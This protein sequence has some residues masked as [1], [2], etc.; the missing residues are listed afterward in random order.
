MITLRDSMVLAV[1]KLRTRKVRTII[2]ILLASMLFGLLITASM[3]TTGVFDS[4]D[5][6]RKDGL[7]SQYIVTVSKARNDPLAVQKL[8]RD[9]VLVDEAKQRYTALVKKKTSEAERLGISYTQASDLPPYMQ[10][11]DDA[12]TIRLN[13]NDPNGIVYN[14]LAQK[15]GGQPAFNDAQLHSIADRYHATAF[16]YSQSYSVKQGSSL[17]VLPKDGEKFYNQTDSMSNISSQD[18]IIKSQFT[19]SPSNITDYFMLPNDAGW[20]PSSGALPII[21]PKDTVEQLLGLPQLADMATT[22]EK[23]NYLNVLRDKA[24]TLTFSACYRNSASLN[25]IQQTLQ[26]QKKLYR[27]RTRKLLRFFTLNSRPISLTRF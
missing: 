20:Q 4:I 16:F 8:L 12:S 2:T 18:S 17:A 7:T 5:N 15:Y 14:L 10:T 1:T 9:P 6:I 3:V 22:T 11:S 13:I 24:E 25:S 27:V 19:I 23:L 21:L 26:Q